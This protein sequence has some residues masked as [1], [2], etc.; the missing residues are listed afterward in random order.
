MDD[1]LEDKIFYQ[2]Y[3]SHMKL[4]SKFAVGV[5]PFNSSV[6]YLWRLFRLYFVRPEVFFCA[7]IVFVF[8]LYL[9]AVELWSRGL[10]NRIS[11]SFGYAA[12]HHKSQLQMVNVSLAEK[13]SWELIKN[14]SAV[15]AVQGRR[16][17]MED[18]YDEAE[19]TDFLFYLFFV[20]VI[21][22][23]IHARIIYIHIYI[24]L[25]IF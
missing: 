22:N 11:T 7:I 19:P 21:S 16:P 20:C 24:C 4:L 12:R 15:Y 18:R 5:P 23:H 10:L 6:S 14:Q 8:L 2:T 25:S 17:K 3:I 9:Q 13:Q 1:E